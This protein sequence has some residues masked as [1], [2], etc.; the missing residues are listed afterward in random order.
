MDLYHYAAGFYPK[1]S[2]FSFR[3]SGASRD[4][5]GVKS[6]IRAEGIMTCDWSNKTRVGTY[7]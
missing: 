5:P 1:N 4:Q 7:R 3:G 6:T 2:P